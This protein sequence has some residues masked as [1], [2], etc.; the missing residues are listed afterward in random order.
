MHDGQ[1]QKKQRT[2][3]LYARDIY[4]GQPPEHAIEPA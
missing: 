1:V 2:Q 3:L 4:D